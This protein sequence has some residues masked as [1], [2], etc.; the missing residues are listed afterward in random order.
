MLR[1]ACPIMPSRDFAATAEF[2]SRLGF[3]KA[4]EHSDYLILRRDQVELHFFRHSEHRPEESDH[5]VYLRPRDV[6]AL[7][8]E[9]AEARIDG[10]PGFPRFMPAETKPWGMREVT[11][12][13]PDGNLL[14]AGT[15]A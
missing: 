1:S 14:R 4:L 3:E 11:V 7:S 13:D 10:G 12:L 5:G 6:D 8:T 9:W 15:E 2:Y